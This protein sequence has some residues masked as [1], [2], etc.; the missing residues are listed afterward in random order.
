MRTGL[1][2]CLFALS[3]ENGN[4]FACRKCVLA[5]T[6][7]YSHFHLRMETISLVEIRCCLDDNRPWPK[8]DK[9]AKSP[10]HDAVLPL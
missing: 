4:N 3:P 6:G 7:A 8:P 10:H 1:N 9:T 2:G 5:L